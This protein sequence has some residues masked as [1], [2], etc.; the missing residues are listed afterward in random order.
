MSSDWFECKVKYDKPLDA[1]GLKTKTVT[2]TY[3]VDA[4]SFTEAEKRF[5]EEITP[6]MTGEFIVSNIRRV[7]ISELFDSDDNQADR[8]FKAKVAFISL[9]EKTG[10]EKYSNQFMLVK[11]I[12]FR[13]ALKQLDKYMASTLGDYKIVSITETPI[14]DVFKYVSQDD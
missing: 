6:F 5:I 9:D 12:D 2:D 7:K 14:L 4:L 1:E 10:E 3:L 11:A 13:D 8:W